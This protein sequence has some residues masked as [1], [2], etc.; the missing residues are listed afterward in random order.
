MGCNNKSLKMY[1][2]YRDTKQISPG[3]TLA[4]DSNTGNSVLLVDLPLKEWNAGSSSD[5]LRHI[6]FLRYSRSRHILDIK[7]LI[8]KPDKVVIVM[9]CPMGGSLRSHF[10]ESIA[11]LREYKEY[12]LW[13]LLT[14]LSEIV[15]HIGFLYS[16]NAIH[17]DPIITPDTLYY[18]SCGNLQL[19]LVYSL[20]YFVRINSCA[21][22]LPQD[23][24]V[25]RYKDTIPIVN[26]DVSEACIAYSVGAIVYE[27]AHLGLVSS[28]PTR[29]WPCYVDF[30]RV[31]RFTKPIS[32]MSARAEVL[33]DHERWR[34][35][36]SLYGINRE[37]YCISLKRTPYFIKLLDCIR[38][39]SSTFTLLGKCI[40][41]T[42]VFKQV[43]QDLLPEDLSLLL[44]PQYPPVLPANWLEDR[45]A[46]LCID[47]LTEELTEQLNAVISTPWIERERPIIYTELYTRYSKDLLSL[48][49]GMLSLTAEKR[50]TVATVV[51]NPLVQTAYH[52]DTP[53]MM[54]AKCGDLQS[55]SSQIQEYARRNDKNN[56]TALIY[57]VLAKQYEA[58]LLLAPHEAGAINDDG[59]NASYYL[60]NA[61]ISEK[62]TFTEAEQATIHKLISILVVH[63]SQWTFTERKTLLMYAASANN[64]EFVEYL[65]DIESKLIDS[66]SM[67]SAE[68]ALQSCAKEAFNRLVREEHQLLISSGY[69]SI[70]LA[71][72]NNDTERLKSELEVNSE[73]IG[74]YSP[75]GYTALMIA[76]IMQAKQAVE[77]LIDYEARMQSTPSRQTALMLAIEASLEDIALVLAERESGLK[78]FT[79]KTALMYVAEHNMIRLVEPLIDAEACLKDLQLNTALMIAATF[80][81]SEAAALLLPR[82][83]CLLNREGLT[84]LMLAAQQNNIEALQVI[85]PYE[86]S[87]K[88][89]AGGATA[90]IH[91]VYRGNVEAVK[92]LVRDEPG[93][94]N[95]NNETS[96]E[97]ARRQRRQD[98]VSIIQEYETFTRH[99]DGLTPLMIDAI[100]NDVLSVERHIQAYNERLR[101]TFTH[102]IPSQIGLRD[103]YGKTAL[104]HAIE[105]SSTEVI[106]L[107]LNYEMGL[108]D[109]S[110]YCA[111]YYSLFA[112][113][114]LDDDTFCRL[115][116]SEKVILEDA[117]FTP[118]MMS[119]LMCNTAVALLQVDE[120]ATM[121][122]RDGHTALMLATILGVVDMVE[123][124]SPLESGHQTNAGYT[125]LMFAV[126]R[127]DIDI[128]LI[129]AETGREF[130]LQE[131]TGWTALMM[132]AKN[133]YLEL[134]ALL[135]PYEYGQR[136]AMGCTALLRAVQGNHFDVVQI[137]ANYEGSISTTDCHP[138]GCGWTPLF[139]AIY[140]GYP[141]CVAFLIEREVELLNHTAQDLLM[142]AQNQHSSVPIERRIL[143]KSI[144]YEFINR[145]SAGNDSSLE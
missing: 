31:S 126:E 16:S 144:I 136:D 103:N 98:L 28:V 122:S 143:C 140:N 129:I 14:Q 42:G 78:T 130:G 24:N 30:Q 64:M 92:V 93:F 46:S 1:D 60:F 39:L 40:D 134:A 79:G 13:R 55:I 26:C 59:K 2:L 99:E 10:D 142:C 21:E 71:A 107:L 117:G 118:L 11:I 41:R 73:S 132:A 23:Q 141:N 90:L 4:R 95:Q 101:A 35:F 133:G 86:S 34:K 82:E 36:F 52:V 81:S 75:Q 67:C 49:E 43:L 127:N 57:A 15:M 113:C 66:N 135:A 47:L 65:A 72:A 80:N 56:N 91:A 110:G 84:A 138:R 85:L 109:H 76:T 7:T 125:A 27:A 25:Q 137:L 77:V 100:R 70:M 108:R 17:I 87:I 19:D 37:Y 61:Y 123:L 102:S 6:Q 29:V 63:E 131:K 12:E 69:T 5:L 32:C 48:L 62:S 22:P 20:E 96:L 45:D 104:I 112:D 3:R 50:T 124:L 88:S 33:L 128:A 9:E 120:Y 106:K 119:V 53:L 68:Y 51:T 97:I 44:S 116:D 58:A 114:P 18:D 89:P 54:A 145:R 74:K 8:Y 94:K 38:G 115:F 83:A 111:I 105:N 139:E 121:S